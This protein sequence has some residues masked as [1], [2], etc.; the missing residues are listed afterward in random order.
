MT[1][2]RRGRVF[3]VFVSSTFSD[4]RHEREALHRVVR[5]HLEA[6]CAAHGCS[7]E[8]V[9]LRWGI[10]EEAARQQQTMQICLGEIARAQRLTPRPNFIA[11]L[12]NRY[13]WCP[14]PEEI[15]TGEFAELL[16][17]LSETERA[18][19]HRIYSLDEN[20]LAPT[21][22]LRRRAGGA[23]GADDTVEAE[24]QPALA[25]AA[26]ASA[27]PAEVK[28]R[29]TASAT[30]REIL[31][32]CLGSDASAR[33]A[34]FYFRSI[35]PLPPQGS[36]YIDTAAD[37]GR[38]QRA[39]EALEAL[40][41]E[42]STLFPANVRR[43]EATWQGE[44]VSTRHVDQFCADVIA[45]LTRSI[46][47]AIVS[48][49]QPSR[50]ETERA[51]HAEFGAQLAG[52][53]VG[54]MALLERIREYL[55]ADRAV[56]L[57]VHGPGG[58]GKSSLLAAA[59]AL[60]RFRQ[61]GSALVERYIAATPS[62]FDP[63]H[64][65]NGLS[66]ELE[67]DAGATSQTEQPDRR[68]SAALALAAARGPTTIFIDGIDQ[69][70]TT[71]PYGP[72]DVFPDRLPGNVRLVVSARDGRL[73]E[74][75]RRRFAQAE[76]LAIPPMDLSECAI[77]LDAI[78]ERN[79]RRLLAS[80]RDSI[81]SACAEDGRP[82]WIRVAS[83]FVR[84]LPSWETPPAL[85][86]TVG[87]LVEHFVDGLSG[88]KLH[89]PVLVHR[90]LGFLEVS[91]F[92][93]SEDEMLGLLSQDAAVVAEFQKESRHAWTEQRL[94][95]I[96]WSRL[97]LDLEA[98]LAETL[99][100][101]TVL[102]RFFH[103]E[104]GE[105][106][107]SRLLDPAQRTQRHHSIAA[108]LAQALDHDA[109]CAARE[110]HPRTLRAVMELPYHL[111]ASG[112]A[113]EYRARLTDPHFL[114]AKA[115]ANR[116]DDLLDDYG[117]SPEGGRG[118]PGSWR[119]FLL[120]NAAILR[121]HHA[122]WDASRILLQLA[123]ELPPEH[124]LAGRMLDWLNEGRCDWVWLRNAYRRD[125]PTPPV[126]FQGHDG[127]I[128]DAQLATSTRLVTRAADNTLRIWDCE[129]GRQIAVLPLAADAQVF[130][131]D[132]TVTVALAGSA[133]AFE[134][135]TGVP[136]GACLAPDVAGI[137]TGRKWLRRA[138]ETDWQACQARGEPFQLGIRGAVID[139]EARELP[140]GG[141]LTVCWTAPDIEP[142]V[143]ARVGI[144][145]G[146]EIFEDLYPVRHTIY[147]AWIEQKGLPLAQ[148]EGR[149]QTDG[150]AQAELR[151]VQVLPDG[152]IAFLRSCDVTV[153]NPK[154]GRTQTVDGPMPPLKG[155]Y[156]FAQDLL[157]GQRVA[158]IRHLE[159]GAVAVFGMGGIVLGCNG[160]YIRRYEELDTLGATIFG[161]QRTVFANADG[162]IAGGYLRGRDDLV[163]GV[164]DLGKGRVASWS[165]QPVLRIWDIEK[166]DQPLNTPSP[167]GGLVDARRTA[168]GAIL[169]WNAAGTLLLWTPEALGLS[170]R[171][172]GLA[173]DALCTHVVK[174][175]GGRRIL[176]WGKAD[177]DPAPR[178]WDTQTGEV[179][180]KMEG[181]TRGIIGAALSPGG[182]VLTWN[183]DYRY[184]DGEQL[185]WSPSSGD[186]LEP[187]P[188]LMRHGFRQERGGGEV[189]SLGS[190]EDLPPGWT[191]LSDVS[192][193][194]DLS[195]WP[196]ALEFA[197]G[198]LKITGRT[199]GN[200]TAEWFALDESTPWGCVPDGTLIIARSSGGL[201]F[202]KLFRGVERI[203]IDGAPIS[204]ERWEAAAQEAPRARG[205]PPEPSTATRWIEESFVQ[206]MMKRN[207]Q[208]T[209]I[210]QDSREPRS[211]GSI[212]WLRRLLCRK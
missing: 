77:M 184:R 178:L 165:E 78:L 103:R 74:T 44:D 108:Y 20:A 159:G 21:W 170:Q 154:S 98:F 36:S 202:L 38:D 92:G 172:A 52:S 132:E 4:F 137:D 11:L 155:A 152:R 122:G 198:R 63:A 71:G 67:G 195:R 25:R 87:S 208:L 9:D 181:H 150:L 91:R 49:Q 101:G 134:L 23:A 82:L 10:G 96:L 79:G 179:V 42:V 206:P 31:A 34:H 86:R 125:I 136:L 14:L 66:E 186:L 88:I 64:L 97:F 68:W 161:L 45:D 62:S 173:D 158:G 194:S 175:L 3:R 130:V 47:E 18:G 212:A 126:V 199:N 141:I 40:K 22:V 168:E 139:N 12:G 151:D 191:I 60:H 28:R 210:F 153:W 111:A 201:S 19:A 29:L 205:K 128:F 164:L 169:G 32:G 118:E 182:H 145:Q 116:I 149:L 80:Q 133:H 8:L 187:L 54:C 90:A 55:E 211:G 15:S 51:R 5:P 143:P 180:R 140:A 107:E 59:S 16:P 70:G 81:L 109:Y 174:L 58:C 30:H 75:L 207:P 200:F 123:L 89:A 41:T 196:V 94:P 183:R 48:D 160:K 119:R 84:S 72:L 190:T 129:S 56:P 147:R 189:E 17:H 99:I 7:F 105:A 113:E 209:E 138:G 171:A 26:Q 188:R 156:S 146:A 120:A 197:N 185:L 193:A 177:G 148:I 135:A 104:L 53:F 127:E 69:L 65:L 203:D 37:G 114:M 73:L 162:R 163:G 110:A 85:P 76:T 112:E 142:L 1:S 46:D 6:H 13:G 166:P 121:R 83:E 24:G 144:R 33:D 115:A 61:P 131:G 57:I 117:R 39:A 192:P 35:A 157:E 27:L 100:D 93:L 43:Y 2:R 204:G 50:Q 124:A 102:Y 106:V 167:I 95:Q 176:S